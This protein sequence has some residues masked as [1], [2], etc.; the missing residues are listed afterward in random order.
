MGE[1]S[2]QFSMKNW[3]EMKRL[4]V[5]RLTYHV[6]YHYQKYNIL[7]EIGLPKLREIK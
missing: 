5:L 3:A 2:S 1:L 7:G 4:T 6:D